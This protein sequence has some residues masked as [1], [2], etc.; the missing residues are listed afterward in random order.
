MVRAFEKGKGKGQGAQR[1]RQGKGKG[2]RR[3]QKK[4]SR[5]ERTATTAD[6]SLL[7]LRRDS[8]S[9]VMR[10]DILHVLAWR[11]RRT[12]RRAA[13]A[14]STTQASMTFLANF[15]V[16]SAPK[17]VLGRFSIAQQAWLINS[18]ASSRLVGDQMFDQM[19]VLQERKVR[20][21][22]SLASG[23]PIVLRGSVELQVFVV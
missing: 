1:K 9:T 4:A 6:R 14:A 12:T 22:C 10:K 3:R 18:G 5:K 20:V 16:E 13:A 11:R 19:E 17:F 15:D 23:E 8:A 2:A 7:H 21:D